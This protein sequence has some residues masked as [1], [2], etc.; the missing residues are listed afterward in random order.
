VH[1][2][3]PAEHVVVGLHHGRHAGPEGRIADGRR[4]QFA[5]HIPAGAAEPAEQLAVVQ[6]EDSQHL[7]DGE[8][9]QAVA[10]LLDHLPGEERPEQRPALCSTGEAEPVPLAGEGDEV[11]GPARGAAHPRDAAV[12]DAAVEEGVDRVLY[13]AAP[14][15]VAALEVLLP[16]PLDLV[17]EGV[18]EGVER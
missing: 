12:E 6:E 16:A 9:P 13:A 11:F 17:V 5:H 3:V 15:A 1:V 2:R 10:D 4:H 7:R 8:R 14:E 18:D